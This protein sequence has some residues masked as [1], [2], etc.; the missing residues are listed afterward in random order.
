MSRTGPGLS[1]NTHQLIGQ[2]TMAV[3]E[4]DLYEFDWETSA[5]YYSRYREAKRA[6]LTMAER[7]LFAES[8][9]D[10][11]ILRKLVDDGCPVDLIRQIVL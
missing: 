2:Y 5:V 3:N 1:L 4:P 10:I 9:T 6:G 11:G 8:D 7:R